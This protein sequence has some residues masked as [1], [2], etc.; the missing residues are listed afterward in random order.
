MNVHIIIDHPRKDSFNHAVLDAFVAGLRSGGHTTDVLD[1]NAEEFDPIFS[2]EELAAYAR[3]ESSTDPVVPG[4][5][6]RLASADHLAMIFPIW[7][8]IMPVRLKGWMDKVL[9]PG[10][11]FTEGEVPEPLLGHIHGATILTTSGA[12]DDIQRMAS[13]NGLEGVLCK[14]AL[15]FCGISPAKWLNFGGAGAVSR[16]E[17]AAWLKRVHEY[18]AREIST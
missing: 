17:H 8:S 10:F 7:W 15:G 16:E 3:G 18:G 1:L 11:A 2:H 4:Y 12:P 9:R 5:Q 13:D 14:G 6:K